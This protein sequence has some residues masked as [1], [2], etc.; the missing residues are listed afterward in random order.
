MVIP[1]VAK[2]G[3]EVPLTVVNENSYYRWQ[4]GLTSAQY[5][6][7]DAGVS[8]EDGCVWSTSGSGKG[9]WAPINFGAGMTGGKSWLALIPNPNN[10]SPANFNV[11]IVAAPGGTV[12]GQCVYENGKFNGGDSG[13][14]VTVS[15]G[16]A[17]Y[18]LYN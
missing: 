13:C 10:R 14:T 18:V 2:A 6:V 4:G 15:S 16:Q 3:S 11:K 7:N 17:Y 9:N 12:D 5:Y 1:T 8:V